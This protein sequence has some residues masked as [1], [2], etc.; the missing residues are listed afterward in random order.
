MVYKPTNITGGPLFPAIKCE[1]FLLSEA[2]AAYGSPEFS[3]FDSNSSAMA[4][5][6]RWGGVP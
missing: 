3:R 6:C 4:V 5:G 1:G 2:T